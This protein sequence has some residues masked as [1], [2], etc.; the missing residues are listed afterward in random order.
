MLRRTSLA[1]VLMEILLAKGSDAA[2][3]VEV[4]VASA[5]CGYTHSIQ[6]MFSAFRP[7]GTCLC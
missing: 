5:F 4:Q 3:K 2:P 6:Q 7:V 1:S